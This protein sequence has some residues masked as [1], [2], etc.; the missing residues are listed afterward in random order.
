M[1]CLY[2]IVELMILILTGIGVILTF[3]SI[4]MIWWYNNFIFK[5]HLF[6]IEN[7]HVKFIKT[8]HK[9]FVTKERK[10]FEEYHPDYIYKNKIYEIIHS[11]KDLSENYKIDELHN[12]PKYIK[13][14]K[15]ND[16]LFNEKKIIGYINTKC[17]R[18]NNFIYKLKQD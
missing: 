1:S 4:L 7:H 11:D 15:G 9:L 18:R 5:I 17:N 10:L 13:I 14:E 12:L 3:I 6:K 8:K 16:G 2:S